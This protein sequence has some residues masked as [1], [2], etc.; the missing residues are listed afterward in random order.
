DDV[1]SDRDVDTPTDLRA[2]SQRRR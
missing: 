2:I 1:G